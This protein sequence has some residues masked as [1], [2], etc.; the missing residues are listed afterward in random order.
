[1]RRGEM[2]GIYVIDSNKRPVL[3][4]IRLG[5]SQGE[6]TEVLTGVSVGERIA[7]DPAAAVKEAR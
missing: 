1:M 7:V 5:K 2:M 6:T 4:Q 3:R